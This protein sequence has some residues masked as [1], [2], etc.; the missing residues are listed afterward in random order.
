MQ[1]K[2]YVVS[3]LHL[4][5]RMANGDTLQS[6]ICHSQVEL[7][8]F[9]DWI[10]ESN[11]ETAVELILNGDIVDFLLEDD[12][13][14]GMEPHPWTRDEDEIISKLAHIIKQSKIAAGGNGPFD[15]L[16]RFVDGGG[17]LTLILGNHDVE[18]SLPNVRQYLKK[19]LCEDQG[20]LEFLFDGEAYTQGDLLVEHG[21]RYDWYNMIDHSALRQERSLL[22]RGLLMLE[23]DYCDAEFTPPAGTFLVTE[24]FNSLK[25]TYRFLDLLKPETGAALPLILTLNP[26]L[27]HVID[28]I[29]VYAQKSI[30]HYERGP[31]KSTYPA[32]PGLLSANGTVKNVTLFSELGDLAETFEV[33]PQNQGQLSA[34]DPWNNVVRFSN[35]IGRWLQEQAGSA[36]AIFAQDVGLRKK[37]LHALWKWQEDGSFDT[38]HEKKLYTDAVKKMSREGGFS[39]IIFGHTHL[40]KLINMDNGIDEPVCYINTGTWA[41]VIQ[42]PEDLFQNDGQEQVALDRFH[43]AMQNNQLDPYIKRYLSYA[44]VVLEEKRVIG[45]G[46]YSFCS[47]AN[48]RAKPLTSVK[49]A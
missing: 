49:P 42:L 36:Q 38:N 13:P 1:K 14:D 16:K 8:D 11:P 29:L 28:A 21:N 41:D 10:R 17:R 46:L 5:G 24:L 3:D 39:V 6:R 40:P 45:S 15:A 23:V 43:S 35:K 44:E 34:T 48:P 30:K 19:V 32:R 27:Q 22:S 26:K 4:G 47:K 31:M 12:F 18:L 20:Q 9:F 33:N 7:R 25:Q 2:V 37:L